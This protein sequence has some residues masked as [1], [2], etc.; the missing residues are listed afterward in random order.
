MSL[1]Y[2]PASEPQGVAGPPGSDPTTFTWGGQLLTQPSYDA[3]GVCTVLDVA[4]G[5]VDIPKPET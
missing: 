2:E 5:A 3:E 4:T 1:K